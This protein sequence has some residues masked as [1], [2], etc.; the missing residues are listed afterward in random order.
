MLK[1][2][3]PLALLSTLPAQAVI[4]TFQEGATPTGTYGHISQDFR[5]NGDTNTVGGQTLVGYQQSGVLQIRT[6]MAFGL[7][8]IPAGSTITSISLTLVSHGNQSG[9]IAGVGAVNLH[10]VIPNGN[11]ANNMVEGQTSMVNWATGSAWTNS[12]GDFTATAMSTAT[13]NNTNSNTTLD[14]GETAVFDSTAAFV[15]AAQSAFDAGLPLEFILVAPTAES[16]TTASNFFRFESDN[17]G[18]AGDRPLLTIEYTIPEPGSATLCLLATG[19][20]M[21]LRR[22]GR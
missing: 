18:T 1:I 19:A 4:I 21:F 7:S 12:L 6:V 16:T 5:G 20:S 13:L 11:P 14:L 3:A 22:R 2:L 9:T 17:F 15:A 8:A 10:E